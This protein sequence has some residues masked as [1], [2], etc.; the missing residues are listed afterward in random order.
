MPASISSVDRAINRANKRRQLT[1]AIQAERAADPK[2]AAMDAR[3]S[4]IRASNRA[5]ADQSAALGIAPGSKD[6]ALGMKLDRRAALESFSQNQLQGQIAAGERRSR[7]V[8]EGVDTALGRATQKDIGQARLDSAAG[9]AAMGLVDPT[10]R[11]AQALASQDEARAAFMQESEWQQGMA[12]KP[13]SE[14]GLV[15]AKARQ[16][17][18]QA[19]QLGAQTGG[20]IADQA[21]EQELHEESAGARRAVLDQQEAVSRVEADMARLGNTPELQ[22]ELAEARHNLKLAEASAQRAQAVAQEWESI[23]NE[24]AA[25]VQMG[26]L[27]RLETGV[28]TPLDR[29]I[30]GIAPEVAATDPVVGA[31]LALTDTLMGNENAGDMLETDMGKQLIAGIMQMIESRTGAQ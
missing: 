18:A 6:E 22:A 10:I 7:E 24:R 31:A 21:R 5:S 25:Q 8:A 13:L 14:V 26:A 9:Q 17:G 23:K 29:V 3:L 15:D 4:L 20:M 28:G 16:V 30:A 11:K 12:R 1:E 2:R 19:E 27:N